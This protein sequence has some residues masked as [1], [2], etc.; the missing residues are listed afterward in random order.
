LTGFI[1]PRRAACNLCGWQGRRFDYFLERRF[2]IADSQCPN[3]KSMPRN[4][5]LIGYIEREIA[6]EGKKVLDIAPAPGYKEWFESRGAR[7][8]SI[9]FGGRGAMIRMDMTR[10]GFADNTFDAAICS[11][12]LEHIPDYKAALFELNRVLK[13]EGIALIDVPFSPRGGTVKLESP[14]HQ[15]HFHNFGADIIERIEEASF[16]VREKRY[17]ATADENDPDNR[18]FA[19]RKAGAP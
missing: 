11:H 14:D 16:K 4:R 15:G 13:E 9:D 12:V 18:F 19:A 8:T 1:G 2:V 10:M 3:C 17:S 7:Y 6:L 5:D